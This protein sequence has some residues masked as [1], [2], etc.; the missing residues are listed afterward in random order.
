MP[1]V[2]HKKVARPG[3]RLVGEADGEVFRFAT[4]V[5]GLEKTRLLNAGNPMSAPGM[6]SLLARGR[7][8]LRPPGGH[9][10]WPVLHWT[11]AVKRSAREGAGPRGRSSS[12]PFS[13]PAA[14]PSWAPPCRSGRRRPSPRPAPRWSRSS[15][16]ASSSAAGWSRRPRRRWRRWAPSGALRV[17]GPV[18]GS[19][20]ARGGP[21]APRLRERHGK[22]RRR[23]GGRE[24]DVTIPL[25][26]S[27][28]G[29][30]D[31]LRGLHEAE[32]TPC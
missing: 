29:K 4:D 9:E 10:P 12:P 11:R 15:P 25:C 3:G 6:V 5:A 17:G 2:R 24:Q 18:L 14:T 16:R 28:H 20:G 22:K 21:G 1:R 31:I 26:S 13:S 23:R 30:G 7:D 8:R 32:G 19:P 27:N